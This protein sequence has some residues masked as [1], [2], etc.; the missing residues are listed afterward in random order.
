MPLTAMPH[1]GIMFQDGCCVCVPAAL[2]LTSRSRRP[3]GPSPRNLVLLLL[4]LVIH[5][6]DLMTETT[7]TGFN[8]WLE[9]MCHRLPLLA[10]VSVALGVA[11]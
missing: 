8:P 2:H 4:P 6:I 9:T 10:H 7:E 3:D 1:V 11:G 5:L